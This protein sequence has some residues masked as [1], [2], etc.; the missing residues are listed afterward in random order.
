MGLPSESLK[1]DVVEDDDDEESEDFMFSPNTEDINSIEQSTHT[2]DHL[3]HRV[4]S[5]DNEREEVKGEHEGP[6]P[7]VPKA[8]VAAKKN[9]TRRSIWKRRQSQRQ[10][11]FAE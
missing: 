4:G 5:F 1:A 9:K 8:A 3:R 6:S 10:Q 2:V 7:N 11:Q